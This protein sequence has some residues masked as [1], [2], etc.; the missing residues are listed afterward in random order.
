MLE[1]TAVSKH[2]NCHKPDEPCRCTLDTV[3][4]RVVGTTVYRNW[5]FPRGRA[6]FFQVGQTFSEEDM[7]KARYTQFETAVQEEKLAR[8]ENQETKDKKV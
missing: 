2:E 5:H 3:E 6:S 1:I 4:T 8:K 7:T